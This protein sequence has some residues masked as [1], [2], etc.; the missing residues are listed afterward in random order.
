V[1]PQTA[2]WLDGVD[3][4][5]VPH[6]RQRIAAGQPVCTVFADAPTLDEC[7]ARLAERAGQVYTV[8]ENAT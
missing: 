7:R 3:V 5:D 6:P 8:I 1:V 4:G 2:G